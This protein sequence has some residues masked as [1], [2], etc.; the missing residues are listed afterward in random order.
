MAGICA[1]G[2]AIGFAKGRSVPSLV[3]G[4]GIGAVYA[5][6]GWKIQKN[7]YRGYDVALLASSLLLFAMGPKAFRTRSIVPVT[8]TTMGT[9]ATAYYGKKAYEERY[10][11]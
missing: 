10:G 11:V 1:I 4:V 8:M 3:A 7:E 6:A 5:Y 9:A 2:G